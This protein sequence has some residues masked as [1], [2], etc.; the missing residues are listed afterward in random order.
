MSALSVVS[1]ADRAGFHVF[2]AALRSSDYF[3]LLEGAGPFTV[4]APS[5]VA[6]AALSDTARDTL[7]Y[8]DR[9]RLRLVL[10]YHIAA[11]KVATARLMGKRIRGVMQA[12]GDVIIDGR[13]DLRVNDADVIK[14]DLMAR[15][16]VVHGIDALLSPRKAAV[17]IS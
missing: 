4:F 11:G 14:A 6:F 17:A 8:Q 5:D 12:G 7:L 15:N 16:G 1:V 10:G 2:A 3:N 9:E 13:A